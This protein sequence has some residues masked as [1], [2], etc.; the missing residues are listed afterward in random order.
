MWTF[1]GALLALVGLVTSRRRGSQ[2][3]APVRGGAAAGGDLPSTSRPP[4]GAQ[5]PPAA[6][7]ADRKVEPDK[8][9]FDLVPPGEPTAWAN[10]TYEHCDAH[11]LQACAKLPDYFEAHT[12][13]RSHLFAPE[14]N[15]RIFLI[16]PRDGAALPPN[17]MSTATNTYKF[18]DP[19]HNQ[20][21]WV[22]TWPDGSPESDDGQLR[23][24]GTRTANS[25][26]LNG[27]IV[28]GSENVT[29]G[30]P[31]DGHVTTPSRCVGAIA[32]VERHS[33]YYHS[34]DYRYPTGYKLNRGV[35]TDE[36]RIA[37]GTI[38]LTCEFGMGTSTGGL[39]GQKGSC[40][41]I[42][43]WTT[44]TED[45]IW[46]DDGEEPIDPLTKARAK[47][48]EFPNMRDLV[49]DKCFRVL[50]AQDIEDMRS[51]YEDMR[52]VEREHKKHMK[53][54]YMRK[55]GYMRKRKAPRLAEGADPVRE[56]AA[57]MPGPAPGAAEAAASTEKGWWEKYKVG[58]LWTMD[59]PKSEDLVPG[60][61]Q[62]H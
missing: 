17:T 5:P 40:T 27:W 18:E 61:G 41:G 48:W 21:F 29:D 46:V 37:G 30:D 44:P 51:H 3:A 6:A 11:P 36:P 22:T 60:Q 38:V 56:P 62:G 23:G 32:G 26:T 49:L 24:V 10:L 57:Q 34:G 55:K 1:L 50:N 47:D 45:I 9:V 14:R 16:D 19:N 59:C 31:C 35:K 52:S 33:P 53:E 15:A 54:A 39:P 58:D 28:S 7:G 8:L 4:P 2:P 13:S 20:A 12:A 25:F 42:Y 43:N